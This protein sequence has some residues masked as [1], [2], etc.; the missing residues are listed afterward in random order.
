VR[1]RRRV[2]RILVSEAGGACRL[3]GYDRCAAALEF[4]HLDR[5][6]KRFGVAQA[7]MG[8]SIERLRAEARKCI[9]LCSNCHAEVESG[10]SSISG[11]VQIG[12]LG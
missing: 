3:C 1:R 6:S 5:S 10:V 12:D 11:V 2:N 8:R 7:G 4:H 9:L